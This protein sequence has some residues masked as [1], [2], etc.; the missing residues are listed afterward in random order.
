MLDLAQ[1]PQGDWKG[2]TFHISAFKHLHCSNMR[3]GKE[4]ASLRWSTGA[5]ASDTCSDALGTEEWTGR[6]FFLFLC[7]FLLWWKGSLFQT[8]FLQSQFSE[9]K[10]EIEGIFL[11]RFRVLVFIWRVGEKGSEFTLPCMLQFYVQGSHSITEIGAKQHCF[12]L[13]KRTRG[14]MDC[15]RVSLFRRC[16]AVLYWSEYIFQVSNVK[17][18]AIYCPQAIELSA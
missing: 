10:L 4:Q 16:N 3:T 13:W 11:E 1:I 8:C 18:T 14:V 17:N 5:A 7:F 12:L 15:K 6:N 9:V 2:E